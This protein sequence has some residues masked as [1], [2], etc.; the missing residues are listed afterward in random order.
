MPSPVA[1]QNGDRVVR[2]DLVH[3]V[4]I[5]GEL[6][7]AGLSRTNL[8][9]D[10]QQILTKHRSTGRGPPSSY[11]FFHLLVSDGPVDCLDNDPV[12]PPLIL[13]SQLQTRL[14]GEIHEFG[15]QSITTLLALI[16]SFKANMIDTVNKT[17][18]WH[19]AIAHVAVLLNAKCIGQQG[20]HSRA[21][22]TSLSSSLI[23]P[24]FTIADSHPH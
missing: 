12:I 17:F 24:K 13:L 15:I 7:R 5:N 14:Y 11:I 9:A 2:S 4:D 19:V 3:R 8:I 16:E 22:E 1:R 20:S 18:L 6:R 23:W 21:D 10:L